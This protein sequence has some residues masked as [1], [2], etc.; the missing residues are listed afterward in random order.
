MG[1]IGFTALLFAG[2][3]LLVVAVARTSTT[4]GTSGRRRWV[5]VAV[6]EVAAVACLVAGRLIG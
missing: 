3:T 2:V 6:L 1:A 5:A 4:T